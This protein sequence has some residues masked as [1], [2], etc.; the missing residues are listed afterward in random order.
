MIATLLLTLGLSLPLPTP[1]PAAPAASHVDVVQVDGSPRVVVTWSDLTVTVVQQG[2]D[3]LSTSWV[4]ANG[5][6]RTI[7]TDCSK[8]KTIEECVKSHNHMVDL[9]IQ[10]APVKGEQGK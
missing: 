8:A 2:T 10:A 7:I 9:M 4:D 3:T 6:K 1:S 5:L